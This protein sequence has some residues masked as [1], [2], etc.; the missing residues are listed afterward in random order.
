MATFETSLK[1]RLIYVFAIP[2]E[3][4][5]DCLKVGETTLEEDDGNFPL[6]NSEVLNKAACDR[7]D[8]Y[9]KTA[10][11]AYNLLH[12]EMTVFFKG[13]TISSFNDKQ[14][15][16]VLERSGVKK[17]TFDTV[18]GA[19]EWFCCD[20]ET[21]KKAIHAV[22]NGRNSLNASDISY[23]Q[24]PIIFRPEQQAAIDKTKKQFKKGAQMLWN[25]KMRFGKTLCALRVA[26]DLEMRRTIILTHRPVVD[27][28]WFEDFGK[29]FY[30]RTD[31]HYGS[32][33]KGEDFTSLERLAKK[34]DR[35]V[36]FASMQDMR[37]AQ[38][39]GGKFDKNNEVFSTDWDFLIVDEAHEGTRTELGE[40]V[41]KELTKANTKVLKL[42]GTPFNLLDD[43][44]E[45]ETYTWDYTME[46][47]AKTE[48]DLLHMGDPNPYASLPAINI[49][50]YDLGA[51]MNDY[52]EDEKAFN[53]REFF[54]TKDDGMFIHEND[55][56]NFLSLLCKEDK[57][58]LY[59][60]SN[61][62]YRSIFR[63]TLW[64][65]PGVKAAR[66]LSAKLKAHSVFGCFEIV[67]VAGNGD[68]DEE[69]ADAL[70]MVNTAIGKNPDETFTI[71]LSC[72][73][74]TT[75]VSIKPW[76][77]VFMM[78]GSYSTSAAGYMQTIFRVQTPFTYKGR[79]KEQCFAFDFA[80]D[81]TLRMLAEVAK[82][83]AK[84]GK[85]TEEDRKILGD[86]LNFCPIISIEGSQMKLYDVNKM[87]GQ[88]KK[89]QIEKV[90]QCGFEDGALY[91]D[92][93]LKLTDI[94]LADF[95]NLKGIIGKTK[96]MPKSGDIDVNKQGFTNE[97]YA[98]KERLEKKPKRER[99][100]EEQARLDELKNRHNQRKD[101]ISIL[102]GISIRMPLLIFGAEL[103]DENEEITIDNFANL[104]DDTSWT[105]FMPKD[106]TKSIFAK[107]KRFYEPDVF[108]EAGKRIRAMARAA[109]KFTIEQRIER[110]ASIFNTFRNPDKETV[111]TPWR[112]VN[113]HINDCL[114]G[115]CF[116]DEEFK[117]PL[118][119]PRFVDKGEV[120]H[121]VFKTDSLIM[122][123]NSKSG[124]YPLLAAY[125]IYRNRLEA[126]K[127]KY[128]EVSNAFS[129]QLWDLT[130]EQ[131][132]LVVCKTPMARSITH[133][134]L[135]GFRDTEVHAEYYKNLIE[136]IS[137]N[138]DLVVNTLR[139]GKNFWGI[140]ENK[141]M[142][143]DAIIGN[144]PYQVVDGGGNGAAAMPIYNKFVCIAKDMHPNY[145]SMIMPAKWYGGGRGLDDFRKMMLNE[146]H[147]D[148]I[149]DFPNPKT[150]FP[151][152]NISGGVCFFRWSKKYNSNV[153]MFVNAIDEVEIAT[154]RQLNEFLQYDIFPRYNEA[155]AILH[156][157]ILSNSFES[158]S[159]IV[160]QYK[161]FG[162]RTYIRGTENKQNGTDV[163]VH[164]S[165]SS[166]FISR[167]EINACLDYIDKYNVITGKAL[168][169]HLG[170]SDENG[171]VKVLAPTKI[172]LPGEVCTESYI[173]M[174]KFDTKFEANNLYK[175]LCTKVVRF[176]LL[177]ALP[178][179]DI[180][181][182]SF[183]FVPLQDFT[184]SSDIDW[185]KSIEDIGRQLYRKYG[186]DDK[187]IGFIERMIKPME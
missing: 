22:K 153:A 156:K 129:L 14:V 119:T 177:Q 66:A 4:H 15:H 53:F 49:Y 97:E 134:T 68:E 169:G 42:S 57:E 148:Y 116:M 81:R 175:Y 141:Y 1:S 182:E 86:F 101:A 45:E 6:P 92:E 40:S 149:K 154:K 91:N 19:N 75:G 125:N 137:Q 187:E 162:L 89:A 50:T 27:E 28:S 85:V 11:I 168:S 136:N 152:A 72:G 147:L 184:N 100:P 161:P 138:P 118:E 135:V 78:A 18:K 112:V 183:R 165:R 79:M 48:W 55:V 163:L 88:L 158:F 110:I 144:P 73:R 113:M 34:G 179:M 12:T 160:A 9:T 71:T 23:T 46:Q 30:D 117:Q 178:T 17:K 32:R 142:T 121:S 20:L 173:V 114:G 63:H 106:V 128:G 56:D 74:L 10:G 150:V 67:N 94:D 26:R 13:G 77:A 104:V 127:E 111:L 62:R 103:K 124:L 43:Y 185:S 176:L 146:I 21:V 16:S 93:L 47:R 105:E 41:I 96:A 64:V 171:Q 174:G 24:T 145:I 39:V 69:N 122:E 120:T 58:S 87:M 83:S 151:T 159:K 36:Y 155:I 172:I 186:L 54:R 143:I 31:Y 109:D 90:V 140:N 70:Q 181:K 167:K 65:V 170:E 139:N 99:T 37:G 98:E 59:P 126:A 108:R 107:F 132:I 82:V 29:I 130:I 76:T 8:Q 52:S 25:A 180:R 5:K 166:G 133:R 123:I 131:N 61:E 102:R 80:P 7:I 2:D 3:W 164:S 51:L 33:T 35:Y 44:T 157:I 60:Y 38:L 115:W 95:K 84:A